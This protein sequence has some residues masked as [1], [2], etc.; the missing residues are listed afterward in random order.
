L[1]IRSKLSFIGETKVSYKGVTN[2]NLLEWF[3]HFFET[4]IAL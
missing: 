2:I 3:G 1:A 4:L